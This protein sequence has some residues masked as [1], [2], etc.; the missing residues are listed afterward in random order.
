MGSFFHEG[1]TEKPYSKYVNANLI[2]AEMAKY[3]YSYNDMAKLMDL[4]SAT[5]RAFITGATEASVR[6]MVQLARILKK[7]VS[8]FFNL[9]LSE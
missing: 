9:E 4:T 1:K 7:P 5:F 2:K 3:G 6:R 8:Y